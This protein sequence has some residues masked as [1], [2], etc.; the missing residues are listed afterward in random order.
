MQGRA[1]D[2]KCPPC[3][4]VGLNPLAKAGYDCF[5]GARKK[6]QNKR[7]RVGIIGLDKLVSGQVLY[8][9]GKGVW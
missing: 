4:S 3:L 6:R 5:N 9:P 7:R 8:V 1:T 2:G